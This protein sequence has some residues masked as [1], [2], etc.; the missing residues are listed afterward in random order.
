[1]SIENIK[2]YVYIIQNKTTK[3]VYVGQ[4]LSHTYDEKTKTWTDFGINGRI[5]K[6]LQRVQ[7]NVDYPLYNDIKKYGFQDFEIVF[8]HI[9]EKNDIIKI[10]DL[11]KETIDKYDSRKNGY[12]SSQNTN[13]LNISKRKIYEFYEHKIERSDEYHERRERRCQLT[14]SQ[15]NRYSFFQDKHILSV[16]VNPIKQGGVVYT[17]RVIFDVEYED[18]QELYRI[19]FSNKDIQ[20]AFSR[21]MSFIKE[22]YE[23]DIDVHPFF[24]NINTDD[25]KEKEVYEKAR[26][27]EEI[28]KKNIEKINGK[29]FF[30][31]EISKYVYCLSIYFDG[32]KKRIM[33][34][35]K[36]I[37]ITDAYNRAKDFIK[38]LN[39]SKNICCLSCPQ[40]ATAQ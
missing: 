12:N 40:Q 21:S 16:K 7:Q 11:E 15:K 29:E 24:E 14:I 3:K 6:H 34:G 4:T 13:H 36:N 27:L 37:D 32:G 23:G 30:H 35:G 9:L 20:E 25:C 5:L 33:F 1:M 39:V 38:R 26:E 19:N 8:E 28:L 31:K 17:V 2:G 22:I 10:D 18:K